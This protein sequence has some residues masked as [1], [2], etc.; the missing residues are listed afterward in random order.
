MIEYFE[1][2]AN[3]GMDKV[4]KV[5][6]VYTLESKYLMKSPGYYTVKKREKPN[7]KWFLKK[8]NK[9]NKI[10]EPLT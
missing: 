3:I 5:T 10:L 6:V 9:I 1:R 8:I 2:L 7:L 4:Y